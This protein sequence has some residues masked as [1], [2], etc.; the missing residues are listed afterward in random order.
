MSMALNVTC[1]KH[2]KTP[3]VFTCEH[4]FQTIEDKIPRGVNWFMDDTGDYQA[5]CDTC[6]TTPPADDEPGPRM[7]CTHCLETA[8]AHNGLSLAI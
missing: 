2:G 6:W 8:A 1:N 7:V 4:V 3:A 5:F